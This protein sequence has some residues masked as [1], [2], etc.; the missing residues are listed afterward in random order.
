MRIDVVHEGTTHRSTVSLWNG[1][2]H[3]LCGKT[4]AAGKFRE[5]LFL[6][7]VTCDECKEAGR[8]KTKS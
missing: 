1:R 4:F 8:T 2:A 3:A 7:S 6:G 5:K